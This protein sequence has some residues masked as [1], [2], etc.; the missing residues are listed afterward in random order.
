MSVTFFMTVM[1]ISLSAATASATE[2]ELPHDRGCSA[3][4]LET[5]LDG[6]VVSGSKET[7]IAATERGEPIRVGW[8]IDFDGDGATDLSHWSAAAFLSVFE[9]E[10]F[11]QVQSIHRQRPVRGEA[12]IAL[13]EGFSAWHGLVGSNGVISGR[14]EGSDEVRSRKVG[15][16][17]CLARQPAWTMVYRSGT[18]GQSLEG[19]KAR[20]FGAVRAGQPIRVGWGLS[21]SVD[22]TT[23]SVEH[24]AEPV[25]LTVV[26]GSDIVAQLPEHIGQRSYWNAGEAYFDSGPVMWRGLA[27]TTG[28]FDAIWVDRS[29]GETVR[30]APQRAVFSWYVREEPYGEIP[31]LSVADG[32]I[33]DEKR[34]KRD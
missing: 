14:M 12:K 13:T 27:S 25:F 26:N 10:I 23:R 3:P 4:L 18:D 1:A 22:G 6:S 5:A 8:F 9:G 7:L 29:S 15:T 30:R 28:S 16:L 20:L 33:R 2:S 32:V 31:T 34:V 19:S 11:T 24:V 17:W 21:R